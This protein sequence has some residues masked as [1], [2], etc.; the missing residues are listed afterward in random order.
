MT[1][2]SPSAITILNGEELSPDV[3]AELEGTF[4]HPGDRVVVRAGQWHG[5]EAEFQPYS[6]LAGQV[7][8]I[9]QT[10]VDGPTRRGRYQLEGDERWIPSAMISE[11][12]EIVSGYGILLE[13]DGSTWVAL[14]DQCRAPETPASDHGFLL[15]PRRVDVVERP[16]RWNLGL[17]PEEPMAP[18]LQE[19]GAQ[20]GGVTLAL[21]DGRCRLIGVPWIASA[22]VNELEAVTRRLDDA[23][24][25]APSP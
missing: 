2:F 3:V 6:D 21:E 15:E 16:V 13:R 22:D 23:N 18:R 11:P 25:P 1:H 8:I 10:V 19:S 12:G 17:G 20:V 4:F 5:A 9:A 7:H 24:E 14:F